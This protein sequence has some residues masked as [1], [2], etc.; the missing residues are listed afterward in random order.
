MPTLTSEAIAVG[1][2]GALGSRYH[3]A[4][5][6]RAGLVLA[7]LTCAAAAMR[8]DDRP[9]IFEP[10]SGQRVAGGDTVR[11]RWGDVAGDIE[12]QELLLS[13]DGGRHFRLV[14]RRLDP[15]A[16]VYVWVVPELPS[17]DAVLALR[18]GDEDAGEVVAGKSAAFTIAAG[19]IEISRGALEEEEAQGTWAPLPDGW[20]GPVPLSERTFGAAWTHV[21]R[22]R[23]KGVVSSRET[24]IDPTRIATFLES[25]PRP[26]AVPADQRVEF[27]PADY[28]RR[29]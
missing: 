10:A 5:T 11:V 17:G 2:P 29:P 12:E 7:L 28:P 27:R 20:E 9:F 24:M 4:A 8:A 26:S 21:R 15:S 25:P 13:L 14:T 16:R 3:A 23:A 22:R 19:E 18:V 6:M 1:D